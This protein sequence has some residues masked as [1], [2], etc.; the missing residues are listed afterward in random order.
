MDPLAIQE[1]QLSSHWWAVIR[2][3][4]RL[5]GLL[6]HFAI[7]ESKI[8]I[9]SHGDLSQLGVHNQFYTQK[10]NPLGSLKILLSSSSQWP[11][12]ELRM[13]YNHQLGPLNNN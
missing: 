7:I 11:S 1:K 10:N 8:A 3:A 6:P 4:S 5:V 9:G 12:K 2:Y 13:L